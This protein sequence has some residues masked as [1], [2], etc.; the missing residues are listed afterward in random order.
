MDFVDANGEPVNSPF[1]F[2]LRH[3]GFKN[4]SWP[5]VTGIKITS[6]ENS[7]GIKTKGIHPGE[8]EFVLH[9]HQIVQLKRVGTQDLYFT[10]PAFPLPNAAGTVPPTLKLVS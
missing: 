3:M 10:L 6:L 4:V 8:E 7:F 5:G 1:K 2:T 9:E